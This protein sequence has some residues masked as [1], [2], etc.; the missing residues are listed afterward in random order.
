MLYT[1]TVWQTS[2]LVKTLFLHLGRKECHWKH[3]RNCDDSLKDSIKFRYEIIKRFSQISGFLY[4]ESCV[5][6]RQ[7]SASPNSSVL[8]NNKVNCNLN[9]LQ[10]VQTLGLPP[11][12]KPDPIVSGQICTYSFLRLQTRKTGI[13]RTHL[14]T[15]DVELK[16]IFIVSIS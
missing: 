2:D 15:Y 14:Y 16:C 5:F 13:K 11:R 10:R 1:N 6:S 9:L 12:S 8:S 7:V 3:I 4:L